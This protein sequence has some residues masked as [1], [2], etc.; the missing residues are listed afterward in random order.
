MRN[1]YSDI[2]LLIIP[3]IGLFAPYKVID[4]DHLCY[5]SI[6]FSNIYNKSYNYYKEQYREEAI[7]QC[8]NDIKI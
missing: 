7:N 5:F 4:L 2:K 8:K 1:N 3:N 6:R